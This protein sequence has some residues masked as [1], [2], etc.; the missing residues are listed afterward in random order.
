MKVKDGV[1]AKERASDRF[2]RGGGGAERVERNQ[3][4][5]GVG[6]ETVSALY[7]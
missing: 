5:F 3:I 6:K 7:H 4:L 1:K 2:Q